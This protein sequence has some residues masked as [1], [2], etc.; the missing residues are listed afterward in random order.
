[1]TQK[2]DT[3]VSPMLDRYV[4]FTGVRLD[5]NSLDSES[6]YRLY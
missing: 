2:E 3:A 4:T 5:F 6:L 1:M